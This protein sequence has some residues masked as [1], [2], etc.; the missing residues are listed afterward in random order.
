M[1]YSDLTVLK[2]KILELIRSDEEFRLAIA[3]AIGYY[4][5]LEEIRKL[6][7]DFNTMYI[8]FSKR[9][10]QIER[11]FEEINKRIS[12]IELELSALT[13]SFYSRALWDDLKEEIESRGERIICKRRNYGINESNINLFI[14]TNK[15]IYVVEVKVKPK[16]EDV[17]VLLAK[18]DLV[19]KRYPSKNVVAVLA[20]ALIGKEIEEYAEEKNV[21][22]Y[23]Y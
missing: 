17:G 2:K 10:E 9:F 20:G 5:L 19:R 4:E 22:I 18:V 6:R 12:R 1:K 23:V 15:T 3:S 16:H 14:E 13:E 11:R 21:K 8:E 7:K